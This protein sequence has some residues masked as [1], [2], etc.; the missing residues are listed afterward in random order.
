MFATCAALA[1]ASFSGAMAAGRFVGDG[2]RA[3]LDGVRL[4]QLSG[5]VG[6]SGM[7]LALLVPHP[8]VALI[9][10]GLVGVGLANVVPVLFSAAARVHG[11]SPAH[12]IA[13]LSGLGYLGMMVGPPIIGVVAEASSLT[14]AL[15]MVVAFAVML[16]IFA[17]RA[18]P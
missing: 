6:A 8:A 14:A 4:L 16:T 15:F 12:G 13:A 17:K 10:F 18:L 11:V 7:G 2:V 9:G 1:Y 5:A 3:R